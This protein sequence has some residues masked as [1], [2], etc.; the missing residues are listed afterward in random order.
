MAMH[1]RFYGS[2]IYC[3][4]DVMTLCYIVDDVAFWYIML[5]KRARNFT[6]LI[7]KFKALGS[8]GRYYVISGP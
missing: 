7:N 3:I 1:C 6:N 2:L 8:Y 5:K 4:V